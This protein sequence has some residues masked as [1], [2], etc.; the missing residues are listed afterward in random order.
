MTDKDQSF[1]DLING[2]ETNDAE[3][4]EPEQRSEQTEPQAQ[5]AQPEP[6]DTGDNE[7]SPPDADQS[8]DGPYVPRRAL[9][10]ERRKRQEYE[11]QI[12]QMNRWMEQQQQQYQQPAPEAPQMPDPWTDPEAAMQWQRQQMEQQFEQRLAQREQQEMQQRVVFSEHLVKQQHEDYDQVTELFAQ[13]AQS[14]PRLFQSMIS[15]PMPA[16]YAYEVGKQMQLMQDVG[17]DPQAYRERIKAEI[18]A[19]MQ[20]EQT[21]GNTPRQPS[22]PVPKSLASKTNAQPRNAKGQFEEHASIGDL[23]DG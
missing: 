22:A 7:A 1:E 21:P 23:L 4:R 14:D 18:L 2:S 17:S 5:D 13:A 8:N 11:Q 19:E 20:G 15:H 9:E 3:P 12:Q 10:D 16:Q 6:V